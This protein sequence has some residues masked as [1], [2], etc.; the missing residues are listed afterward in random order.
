MGAGRTSEPGVTTTSG[1][2]GPIGV[3]WAL[4]SS[5][6]TSRGVVANGPT[7]EGSGSRFVEPGSVVARGDFPPPAEA[8]SPRCWERRSTV[9][10]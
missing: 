8:A 7:L 5:G 9:D 2:R 10:V 4:S 3:G 6:V 1:R